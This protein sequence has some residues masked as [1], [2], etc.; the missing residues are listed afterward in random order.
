MRKA[1]FNS[2]RGFKSKMKGLRYENALCKMNPNMLLL[3]D[4]VAMKEEL[5]V[6]HK[7]ENIN[8]STEVEKGTSNVT[9]TGSSIIGGIYK[10]SRSVVD[11]EGNI[12]ISPNSENDHADGNGEATSHVDT[13]DHISIAFTS[14]TD[15][16]EANDLPPIQENRHA[17]SSVVQSKTDSSNSSQPQEALDDYTNSQGT[18][19][20]TELLNKYYELEDQ[21]QKVLQQLQQVGSWNYP[22]SGEG[23]NYASQVHHDPNY[24]ACHPAFNSSCCPYA[25]NCLAGSWPSMPV[26]PLAGASTKGPEKLSSLEN[27]SI[28]K[29]AMGAA[30]KVISSMKTMAPSTSNIYEGERYFFLTVLSNAFDDC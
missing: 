8:N 20:Y 5:K 22:C 19:E 14:L 2:D 3:E 4:N 30:E 10:I 9:E 21:R 24:Q 23:S 12:N 28:V 26:C 29:T 6:M 11:L 16:K 1:G 18:L 13:V 15:V 17:E 25:C 27:E 7:K